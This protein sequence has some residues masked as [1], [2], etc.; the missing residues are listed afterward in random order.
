MSGLA[1]CADEWSRDDGSG[2]RKEVTGGRMV[3]FETETPVK[4][5]DV[6][7]PHNAANQRAVAGVRHR[8]FVMAAD[9]RHWSAVCQWGSPRRYF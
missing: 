3:E 7:A 4:P 5:V 2:R 9:N 1:G 6:L 8:S